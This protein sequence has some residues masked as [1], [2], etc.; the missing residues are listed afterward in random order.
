MEQRLIKIVYAT[1]KEVIEQGN[2]KQF[3]LA[4]NQ[5]LKEATYSEE[6]VYKAVSKGLIEIKYLTVSSEYGKVLTDPKFYMD[7]LR[8]QIKAEEEAR[9]K[10]ESAKSKKRTKHKPNLETL[11]KQIATLERQLERSMDSNKRA[12]IR[13]KIIRKR[14]E[15]CKIQHI[16]TSNINN[17]YSH[18]HKTKKRGKALQV[19]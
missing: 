2:E 13:D 10:R 8:A 7:Q 18:V 4:D 9:E 3:K 1:L 19:G 14:R 11:R 12:D 15:I 6:A 17:I 5:T 16:D